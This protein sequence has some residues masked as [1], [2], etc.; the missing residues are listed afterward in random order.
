M[1]HWKYWLRS[2]AVSAA[3]T[4]VLILVFSLI[5]YRF[6]LGT[7]LMMVMVRAIYALAS[8]AGAFLLG[9]KIRTRRFLWGLLF[10]GS[11]LVLTVLLSWTLNG[12]L[13]ASI[14][15]NAA[16]CLGGGMLGG[17]LS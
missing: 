3:V 16:L 9:K 11:Y 15:W 4:A 7:D 17:M 13:P 6:R 5:L 1:T 12:G 8:F 14:L 10:G 2:L